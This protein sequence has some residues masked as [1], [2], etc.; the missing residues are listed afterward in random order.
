MADALEPG[1]ANLA[2]G[3]RDP[4]CSIALGGVKTGAL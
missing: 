2:S 3:T 1:A 4:R